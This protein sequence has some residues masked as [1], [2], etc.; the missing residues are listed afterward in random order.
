[1]P[2]RPPKHGQGKEQV[3]PTQNY[4]D[5]E[6]HSSQHARPRS[7][8]RRAEPEIAVGEKAAAEREPLPADGQRRPGQPDPAPHP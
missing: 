4:V 1:M 2:H 7:L 5:C 3:A 8:I 6:E